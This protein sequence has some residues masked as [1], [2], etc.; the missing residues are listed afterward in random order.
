MGHLGSAEKR[1]V[2][3]HR[4]SSRGAGVRWADKDNE[5]RRRRKKK[6]GWKKKTLNI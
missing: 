4:V 3:W 2:I 5:G 1:K 6:G